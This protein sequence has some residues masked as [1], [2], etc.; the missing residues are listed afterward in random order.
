MN[1]IILLLLLTVFISSEQSTSILE[2]N[3]VYKSFAIAENATQKTLLQANSK[4]KNTDLRPEKVYVQMD[5]TMYQPGETV[6]FNVFI[7]DALSHK[8]SKI[9]QLVYVQ[10]YGQNG[11]I[12]KNLK[13]PVINGEAKGDIMLAPNWSGGRYKLRAFTKWQAQLAGEDKTYGFEK[14][15]IVQ[16][17]ILP[18][19]RMTLEFQR[20]AYGAGAMMQ[21]DLELKTLDDQP[22]RYHDFEYQISLDGEKIQTI[23]DKTGFDGKAVL[24]YQLSQNLTTND[25]LLNVL[26]N[27]NGLPESISRA[28]P[29]V[30]NDID[31]QFLPESGHIIADAENVIAFK[32]INE[33]GKPADISGA[34][35]NENG[36]LLQSFSSYHQGMGK[37]TISP[38]FGQKYIVKITAPKGIDKVYSLPTI[39]KSSQKGIQVISQTEEHLTVKIIGKYKRGLILAP[40]ASGYLYDAIPIQ[41]NNYNALKIPIKDIPMGILTLTLHDFNEKPITERLVF[42]H[43]QKRLNIEIKTDKKQYQPREKV[44]MSIAIKTKDGQPAKGHF[45][46]SVVDDKLLTFADDRQANI[47]AYLLLQSELQGEIVEPNFYFDEPQKH[48]NKDQAIALDLL[49]MTQG[50]RKYDWSKFIQP[51]AEATIKPEKRQISGRVLDKNNK[52]IKKAK[53]SIANTS[54]ETKTDRKGRFKFEN[55]LIDEGLLVHIEHGEMLNIISY[56]DYSHQDIAFVNHKNPNFHIVKRVKDN[57]P[58]ARISGVIV[59]ES[60]Y[61]AIGATIVLKELNTGAA[62][63]LDGKFNINNIAPGTYKIV[64]S[65]VGFDNIEQTINVTNGDHLIIKFTLEEGKITLHEAVV[66]SNSRKRKRKP[67]SKKSKPKKKPKTASQKPKPKVIENITIPK[68]NESFKPPIITNDN[69]RTGKTVT[70]EDI[71]NLPTRSISG[72][73]ATTAG[74]SS[75]DNGNV[76]IRGSRSNATIVY[77]DGIRINGS[78]IPQT[79]AN[80][81]QILSGGLPANYP[82]RGKIDATI[83]ERMEGL[84]RNSAIREAPSEDYFKSAKELFED[85]KQKV[86][87]ENTITELILIDGEL[88]PRSILKEV[89]GYIQTKDVVEFEEL[90]AKA[91][92]KRIH[93]HSQHYTVLE[94]ITS[95][96]N[97]Q[98]GQDYKSLMKNALKSI[99]QQY[100]TE[101][102]SHNELIRKYARVAN[103]TEIAT[104]DLT[105]QLQA[106]RKKHR[107][108]QTLLRQNQHRYRFLKMNQPRGLPLKN[109]RYISSYQYALNFKEGLYKAREFYVP[110]YESYRARNVEIRTDFRSTIYWNPNVILDAMGQATVEFYTNDDITTFKATIEGVSYGGKIGRSEATFYNQMP[111]S[112]YSKM[113]LTAIKGDLVKIPLTLINNTENAMDGKLAIQIPENLTIQGELPTNIK[114]KANEKKTIYLACKVSEANAEG[115]FLAKFE[116]SRWKDAFEQTIKT[117]DR[118]FPMSEILLPPSD[119]SQPM[120][121]NIQN[122]VDNSIQGQITFY[123]SPVSEIMMNT[124][125]MIR[126]PSG[127]FE[128]VSS[129]N[130]PNILAYQYLESVGQLDDVTR[131]RIAG[132]LKSGLNQLTAYEIEGGGFDWYGRGPAHEG[133]TAYG[134]M[135]F[136]EMSK[137]IEV[138][139]DL[140]KRTSRWLKSR[141][142]GKGGF[143]C[144]K[145]HYNWG[146][147]KAISTAYIVW[148]IARAGYGELVENEINHLY[149][150]ESKDPYVLGLLANSLTTLK[151]NRSEKVIQ[152]L[153]VL[154]DEN[155]SWMG[156]TRSMTNSAGS[157]LRIE[158]TALAA[159]ALM[160]NR[161]NKAEKIHPAT[162]EAIVYLQNA[163]TKYGYG[164]TQSTVLAMEALKEYALATRQKTEKDGVYAVLVNGQKMLEGKYSAN[165]PNPVIIDGFGKYLKSG[166]ND[167][168]VLFSGGKGLNYDVFINYMAHQPESTP[169]AVDL[170]T[171]LQ[172]KQIQLG[173]TVRLTT[174]IKNTANQDIPNTL[175]IVGIPAG[176]TLQPWQ[177]KALQE[178]NAFD[179]YELLDG[180]IIFHF[181]SLAANEEKTIHL[182]L[183]ADI[184]GKFTASASSAYLYYDNEWVK[185]ESGLEVEILE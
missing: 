18:K 12:L 149:E 56:D 154:Q 108:I 13:L 62:A 139:P 84:N 54:Y 155:G 140:I 124:K 111:F 90:S 132:L 150:L 28:I 63:D 67:R 11:S 129:S 79:E 37:F 164:S 100:E 102:K 183:K 182:D 125:R 116:A 83:D 106:I 177:L 85:F 115:Q 92:K 168:Q 130:Y 180:Q 142:D 44:K 88:V 50:W 36:K 72:I 58:L 184:A 20:K 99:R 147:K 35:Y 135:Q 144:S 161:T 53:V 19:L 55:I 77:V 43:P 157:N 96:E 134:L 117:F 17:S 113:P 126:Q 26:M 185:W 110:K 60:G 127:C 21:A 49:M 14:E 48:P 159:L 31:V 114:L 59:D 146:D 152:Q 82:G 40:K 173:E 119:S 131:N 16:K 181:L 24:K 32:A 107:A 166:E 101:V 94:I 172:Q 163:K 61:E 29:I 87:L 47:M 169:C 178:K 51:I 81:I 42:V 27:Y 103:G 121:V 39:A 2:K 145:K 141:R 70:A 7:R 98:E 112:M 4:E 80:Q 34:L 86:S 66:T 137:I 75:A 76:T 93:P 6:W 171:T 30:L 128:Q 148:A 123:A 25:G 179:Y 46:L 10:L 65:Y 104:K 3:Q 8:T 160:K 78:Y 167:I 68:A 151:D 156:K 69:T 133:L 9:S 38:E 174:T 74:V 165:N 153:L 41:K 5:K 95:L 64:A 23:K 105:Q 118:G 143:H 1:K 52:P 45:G 73:I 89:I 22:L 136:V 97:V 15:V 158:A 71:K 91:K 33:F 176:L 170:T 109:I 162:H 122:P 175:A 138:S 57:T 120:K